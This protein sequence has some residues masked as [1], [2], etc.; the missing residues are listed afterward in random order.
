MLGRQDESCLGAQKAI[1]PNSS[2]DPGD[3][4][5]AKKKTLQVKQTANRSKVTISEVIHFQ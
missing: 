2:T 3:K 1:A 4:R 5:K